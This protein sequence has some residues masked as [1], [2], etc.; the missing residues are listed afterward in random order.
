VELVR[1]AARE[2]GYKHSARRVQ[3]RAGDSSDSGQHPGDPDR[4]FRPDVEGLR[5]V[6]V[7]LVVLFHAG[8]PGLG[9]GYVGVDVFFV[10][11]G[12]VITRVLLK[13]IG[14]SGRPYFGEFYARRSRRILPAAGLVVLVTVFATYRWLGFI[15]GDEVANDAR[16]V[17]VFLGNFHFA[18]QGTNYLAGQLPPSPLQNFWSLGVE[19]QFYLIYPAALAVVC[20]VGRRFTIQSRLLVFTAVIFIVSYWWSIHYTSVNGPAAFFSTFTHAWELAIGGFIAAGDGIWKRLNPVVAALL[21]WLGL[22]AVLLAG[23]HF[24]TGTQYPGWIAILPVGGT[25]LVVIGGFKASV[26][27]AEVFLG[28]RPMRW[29][30]KISFS[31][32]LW[33]WPILSIAGEDASK[34]LRLADKLCL[35]AVSVLLAAA[36]YYAI[37]NPVRRSRLLAKHRVLSIALGLVIVVMMLSFATYKIRVL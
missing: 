7:C 3:E 19:E 24:S 22:I 25:A 17:A 26:G 9:G 12:F 35:V 5:A 32:Y 33:H 36:T 31:I 18:A 15:R 10:I 21:A 13:R 8:V 14:S 28:A 4:S 11:S 6:A 37:E 2:S 23:T 30:G 27:G 16:W 20:L 34:P 29:I 1:R